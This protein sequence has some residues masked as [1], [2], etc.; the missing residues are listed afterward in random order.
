M[1][2]YTFKINF[3]SSLFIVILGLLAFGGAI[4]RLSFG[5]S[6]F[7]IIL[8]TFFLI[9]LK[10]GEIQDTS[11]FFFGFIIYGILIAVINMLVIDKSYE[12]FIL[13][14]RFYL[15]IPLYYQVI[16]T[17]DFNFKVLNKYLTFILISYLLIFAFALDYG[18][19]LFQIFNSDRSETA[20]DF[21]GRISGPP[22]IFISMLFFITINYKPKLI[23]N[24]LYIVL[25]AFVY[26]KTGERTVLLTNIMPVVW[27]IYKKRSIWMLSAVPI[28]ISILPLYINKTQIKRFQAIL[29]PFDDPAF[30]Y[31]IENFRIM[32]FEKMPE[33]IHSFFTGFGIGSVYDAPVFHFRVHSYFLDNTF[34]MLLY[35]YG[36]FFATLFFIV[37]YSKSIHLSNFKRFFL[38]IFITIP[39]LT[40]YHLILQPAY[41]IS[42]FFAI[43]IFNNDNSTFLS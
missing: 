35:K 23:N 19:F 25:I 27:L 31:R 18:S 12:Y 30:R 7:D 32:L 4:G 17:F 34:L 2:K 37:I 5:F 3:N 1:P 28:F 29:S 8:V 16:R 10:K 9:S 41:L 15:Y 11:L 6:L 20:F 40:S 13:E 24:I 39:A 26:I 33:Y 43:K 38:I 22:T 36:F 21:V 42:Y 14:L